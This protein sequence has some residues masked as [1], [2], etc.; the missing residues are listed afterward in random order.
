MAV[1]VSTAKVVVPRVRL[2]S[3]G[4][5]PKAM[6]IAASKSLVVDERIKVAAMTSVGLLYVLKIFFLVI[7]EVCAA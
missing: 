3:V 4:S 1:P 5:T 2:V 6:A 7:S